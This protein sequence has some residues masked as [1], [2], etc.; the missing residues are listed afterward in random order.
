MTEQP[1]RSAQSGR[2]DPSPIMRLTTAYW[3]SQVL[4]TANRI[5]LFTAIGDK[6]LDAAGV[7]EQLGTAVRPTQLLLRACVGLGLLTESAEGFA[8]SAISRA[9]LVAGTPGYMGNA[10]RYSDNLYDAWGHLETAMREGKPAVPAASYL[11]SDP[12]KTRHFV[13]GMHERALGIGQ[14]LVGMVDLSGRRNMLDVGGGPGTYSALF[15]QR[16]PDLH[17]QVLDLPDVVAISAT[18]VAGMGVGDRVT[19]LPGDYFTTRFPADRDVVLISGVFHR[20]TEAN[21]RSLIERAAASLNSG[22][23]LVISD[24]FTDASG[25]QP[26]FATLFGLNMMLTAPDGGVHAD[27]AVAGWMRDAGLQSREPRPFPP[28]MPH[29]LVVG[30]KP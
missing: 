10:I 23:L 18:I 28:P 29:R 3:E 22:G 14:A 8:N 11:G 7:A 27:A 5:G 17:S 6:T 1:E 15:A 4:L 26:V 21:C 24:V 2:P 9:F 12:E 30:I 19:T 16:Y 13:Y 25:S 20:E